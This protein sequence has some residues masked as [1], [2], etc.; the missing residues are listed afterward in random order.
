[1]VYL[2]T[3][4]QSPSEPLPLDLLFL[5][6]AAL[7]DAGSRG[8]A[9]LAGVSVSVGMSMTWSTRYPIIPR[10]HCTNSFHSLI[11]LRQGGPGA[12]RH[13]YLDEQVLREMVRY[14]MVRVMPIN[15]LAF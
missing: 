8:E 5:V 9:E 6:A 14:Q 3:C 13:A 15:F 2:T 4:D 11:G 7:D 10:R 12:L 1:M